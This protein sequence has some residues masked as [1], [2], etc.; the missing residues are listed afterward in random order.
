LIAESDRVSERV[1]PFGRHVHQ[2]LLDNLRSLQR[3]VEILESRNP[4]PMHPL[5]IEFDAFFRDVPIH[6]VPPDAGPRRTGR[7]FESLFQD[8]FGLLGE[9]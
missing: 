1:L 8:I 7:V 9:T 6:P 5:E 3:R 2:S 4:C